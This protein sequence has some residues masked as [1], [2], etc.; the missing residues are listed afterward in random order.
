MSSRTR[1]A[2]GALIEGSSRIRAPS[3]PVFTILAR[4]STAG[5]GGGGVTV[6][7]DVGG[8]ARGLATG[9][10]LDATVAGLV[11]T[12]GR[13]RDDSATTAPSVIA[14]RPRPISTGIRLRRGRRSVAL[15]SKGRAHQSQIAADSGFRPPQPGH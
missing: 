12:L 5:A 1:A 15:P 9:I 11:V 3:P 7:I 2:L 10:G 6:G 13:E 8:I 4:R 14:M